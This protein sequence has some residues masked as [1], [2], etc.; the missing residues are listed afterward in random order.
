MNPSRP[1]MFRRLFVLLPILT[2]NFWFFAQKGCELTPNASPTRA[3][4]AEISEPSKTKS[5][6]LDRA[7]ALLRQAADL[8]DKDNPLA[9]KLIRQAIAI[10][11]QEAMFGINAP[12]YDRVS[13]PSALE[14]GRDN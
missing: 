10:L 5:Q 14:M 1:S 8:V 9:V 4:G 11:K 6:S 12:D 2:I 7:S 3:L 13:M